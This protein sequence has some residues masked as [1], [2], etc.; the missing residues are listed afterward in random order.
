MRIHDLVLPKID[1]AHEDCE[2]RLRVVMDEASGNLRVAVADGATET[3][4]SGEWAELLV[5]AYCERPFADWDDLA[6]RSKAAAKEWASGIYSQDRPWHAF[7]RAQSGGAAAIAGIEILTNER[8]WSAVA[9]GD[10]CI[11]QI[12]DER[13][14]L[15][16]PPYGAEEF[17][18][19]PR[20]IST[21]AAKNAGLAS[22]YESSS[23]SYEPGDRFVLA[24]DAAS[25]AFLRASERDDG[26]GEWL[27]AL[28]G[29]KDAAR[30]FIEALR[31]SQDIRDDDVA[32][33]M[34][35]V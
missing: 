32:I 17:G 26:L 9:L 7:M 8:K 14:H 24:T 21:D 16:L 34:I 30:G 20:L 10:S 31:D 4:F 28:A 35:E 5:H 15:A 18:N 25:E 22:A 6:E 13:I 3:A 27:R 33:V 23:G 29:G 12:R 2:D 19:H 11:F 1:E